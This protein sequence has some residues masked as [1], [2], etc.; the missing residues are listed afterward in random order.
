MSYE[1]PRSGPVRPTGGP[2]R[3]IAPYVGCQS[4][5]TIAECFSTQ[6][7]VTW[8]DITAL[9]LGSS[10]QIRVYAQ[11]L[12]EITDEH[13]YALAYLLMAWDKDACYI[14]REKG[15]YKVCRNNSSYELTLWYSDWSII[16]YGDNGHTYLTNTNIAYVIDQLRSWGYAP[17][18]D[19][20]DG[21]TIYK[22]PCK[23]SQ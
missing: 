6:G 11:P 10:N 18:Q 9:S 8:E 1:Q 15:V 19:F 23:T 13:L 14:G 17:K 20:E 4:L 3:R 22:T 16:L 12:S 2:Q 5:V 21:I 7:T